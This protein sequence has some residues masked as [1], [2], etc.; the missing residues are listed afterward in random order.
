MKYLILLALVGVAFAVGTS[1]G[2]KVAQAQSSNIEAHLW[3]LE[4]DYIA[5]GRT[6]DP[7]GNTSYWHDA[8]LGWPAGTAAPIGQADGLEW[9]ANLVAERGDVSNGYE[10]EEMALRLHNDVAIAHYRVNTTQPEQ[11]STR[12]IHVWI[13]TEDGWKILGGASSLE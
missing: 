6:A 7:V 13:R 8:F 12:V 10:F 2:T 5:A 9:R 3:Q 1:F 11:T 4:H